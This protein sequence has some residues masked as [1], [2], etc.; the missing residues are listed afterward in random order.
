[1]TDQNR[2]WGAF[3]GQH[4]PRYPNVPQ[5]PGYSPPPQYAA[6]AGG[7]GPPLLGAPQ[8][9]RRSSKAGPTDPFFR[10]WSVVSVILGVC[11]VLVALSPRPAGWVGAVAGIFGVAAVL[12]GWLPRRRIPDGS[13]TTAIAGIVVSIFAIGVTAG[14]GFVYRD[15]RGGETATAAP[16][17]NATTA[18]VLRDDLD[19]KVGSFTYTETNP[20]PSYGLEVTVANKRDLP[21]TFHLAIAGFEGDSSTQIAG[22]STIVALA[23]RASEQ[24]IMFLPGRVPD[25]QAKRL[26]AGATFRVIGAEAHYDRV[27]R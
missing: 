27:T 2:P 16:G 7:Y 11:G 13:A 22:S 26:N 25:E 1:M 14:M 10:T 18:E 8:T 12:I 20:L 9:D 3:D 17:V 21:A 5:A 15:H 4:T 19:V 23:G 24:I 6:P